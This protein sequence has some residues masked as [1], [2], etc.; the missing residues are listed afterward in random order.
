MVVICKIFD[1]MIK[2]KKKISFIDTTLSENY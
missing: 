1:N 2:Y